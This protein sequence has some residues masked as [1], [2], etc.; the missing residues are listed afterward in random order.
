MTKAQV[1]T[2][3]ATNVSPLVSKTLVYH[4]CMD[5]VYRL[6][7]TFITA[8]AL[9]LFIPLKGNQVYKG[10][11]HISLV[12]HVNP[13]LEKGVWC[14]IENYQIDEKM[15]INDC[16]KNG[17]SDLCRTMDKNQIGSRGEMFS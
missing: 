9:H 12:Q 5:E 10:S 6:L 3:L 15:H 11:D 16:L 13:R 8:Q 4:C 14:N 1:R 17:L 2:T 7:Y